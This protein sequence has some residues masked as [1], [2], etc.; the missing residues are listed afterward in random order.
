MSNIIHINTKEKFNRDVIMKSD[1]TAVL[2]D[3]WADWCGPCK[4]MNPILEEFAKNHPEITVVK[5]DVENDG[6]ISQ[7]YDIASIPTMLLFMDRGPRSRI[8][9]AKSYVSLESDIAGKVKKWKKKS[10]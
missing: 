7:H 10:N 9:G 4:I 6:G 8:I 5:I 1:T 3:F 2:V